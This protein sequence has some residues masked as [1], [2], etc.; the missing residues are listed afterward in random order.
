[1]RYRVTRSGIY[2]YIEDARTSR[3]VTWCA[4]ETTAEWL[5]QLMNAAAA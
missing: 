4:S 3:V 5:C 1:M 2:W